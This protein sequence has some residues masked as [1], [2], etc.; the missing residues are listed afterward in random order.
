[1]FLERLVQR[2]A[3]GMAV[4]AAL[5]LLHGCWLLTDEQY[6]CDRT[7]EVICA[8]DSRPC[9][10]EKPPE[11][12]TAM[13][14]CNEA[15]VR[16]DNYDGNVHLCIQDSGK[17]FCAVIDGMLRDDGSLCGAACSNA[18]SPPLVRECQS[19]QH[20]RCDLPEAEKETLDA[21]RAKG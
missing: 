15:D 8:C 12:V 11:I 14:R 10:R 18:C 20:N 16:P 17:G 5:S 4:L 9:D 2:L 7:L 6:E 21:G 19:Y 13:R 1:M 3:A